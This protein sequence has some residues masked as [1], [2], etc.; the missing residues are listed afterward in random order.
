M[1]SFKAD[2]DIDLSP[3]TD[4]DQ[5]GVR[6]IIYDED[7]EKIQPHPSGYYMQG[8]PV[9]PETGY[10]AIEYQDAESRGF[11]KV[12]LL[13]NSA[14]ATFATKQDVLDALSKEP[15]W[16]KLQDEN[17]VKQLP[18]IANYYQL[19]SELQ[20]RSV[21]DLADVLALIRPGKQHL[22]EAYKKDKQRTR[23]NLYRAPVN[24]QYWFK[25]SHSLS[26]AMMIVCVL[27][28]GA[29]DGLLEF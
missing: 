24:G 11:H 8:M 4:K 1:T 23:V 18:H 20:P 21:E 15:D 10:A 14:Y 28:S 5:Y 3:A 29:A 2:V 26:Y 22:L 19:I 25:Y 13:T 17:I 12:D 16:N 9:D 27:N 6:A 7:N